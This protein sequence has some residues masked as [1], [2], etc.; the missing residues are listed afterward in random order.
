M[1][2]WILSQHNDSYENRRLLETFSNNS[3][4]A[5][6]MHPDEFDI[7]V[8]RSRT[9][10]IRYKGDSI[11][12]PKLVL[13]RV[14]S[15]TNYFRS[16]VMRQLEK[17]SV[18]TINNSEAITNVGDKLLAHQILAQNNI[19][20]P[21]TMLVKFPVSSD[22]VAKE[23]GFPCV[24]KVLQGSY[25]K[26]VHL[27]QTKE[28]FEDLMELIDNLG[29]KKTMIV[30]EFINTAVGTDLRVWVVG[31]KTIGVM[32]RTGPPGDFR[33]NI[34]GGGTGESF[35]ITNELDLLCRET[36]KCLGLDIAGI[37]LLFDQEG[38]KVCEANS[39]PGFEGFEKYCNIDIA[40]AIIDY[41]KFKLNG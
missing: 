18:P 9:K 26:G 16:A 20:T 23:I 39:A 21:K 29:V 2:V 19:P 15:G 14:G 3:I 31:G 34:T 28:L 25:G 24:V 13:T 11:S 10:S 37:D 33:A 30:Q 1:S 22:L 38:F 4:D 12:M 5:R 40:G 32:K 7:I 8:N 27:C 36:A 6:L 41:V 35:E 17:F